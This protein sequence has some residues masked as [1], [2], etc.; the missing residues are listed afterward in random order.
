MTPFHSG[1]ALIRQHQTTKVISA[2]ICNL[3]L[4]RAGGLSCLIERKSFAALTER[5]C[6]AV[7]KGYLPRW[8][9]S[10]TV[11]GAFDESSGRDR[12]RG[13]NGATAMSMQSVAS[14]A[15]TL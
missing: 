6:T 11:S 2:E 1:C 12:N 9:M 7:T 14:P 15:L 10:T 8:A 3:S 5:L 4:S 13:P